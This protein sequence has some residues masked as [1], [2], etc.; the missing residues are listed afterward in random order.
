[1]LTVYPFGSGSLFT[2]SYAVSAS[3]AVSSSYL[4]YTYTASFAESGTSGPTGN[5]GSPEVCLITYDQ[6][7]KLIADPTLKE[8][9]TFVS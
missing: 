4:L 5:R 3:Y 9:C 8:V 6:Y 1:M 7:L 2:G